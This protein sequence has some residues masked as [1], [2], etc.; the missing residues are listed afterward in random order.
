MKNIRTIRPRSTN[1]IDLLNQVKLERKQDKRKN[2]FMIT[3]AVSA[4]AITSL[5]IFN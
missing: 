2:F 3:A 4:F 5:I 1:V